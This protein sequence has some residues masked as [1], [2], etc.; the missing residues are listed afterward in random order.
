MALPK[1]H[2]ENMRLRTQLIGN[3]RRRQIQNHILEKTINFPKGVVLEDIDQAF[4]EWVKKKL[5]IAFENEEV[6]TVKLFSNQRISE[7]AQTWSHVD[8]LGNVLM[9]IKFISRENNPKKGNN[10][11]NIFNIPGDRDYLMGYKP[12]LQEN[13]QEAYDMY[14]MKQPYTVDLIYTINLI[15]NKYK[16][17]NEMNQLIHKEF[18]A[19]ESYL[20]PNGHAMPMKLED[21]SDE[22]EYGKDDRRYYSQAYKINLQGYIIDPNGFK[23]THVPSRMKIQTKSLKK[24]NDKENVKVKIEEWDINDDCPQNNESPFENQKVSIVIDFPSCQKEV[25]FNIDMNLTIDEIE[26]DNIHDFVLYINEEI[27]DFENDETNIYEGDSIHVEITREDPFKDSK[28]ILQCLNKDKIFDKR[29]N[30][31]VSMDE[32]DFDL[33]ININKKENGEV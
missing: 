18:S 7:Y 22:S 5:Y 33:E 17:I 10:Q 14:T 25:D 4:T 8:S 13:G 26:L 6:P 27:Q 28:M 32:T 20:F 2:I 24:F 16:L 3:P 1:K 21:V 9:N 12:I 30:P 31:E 29:K 19:L 11:G 23:I 15:T